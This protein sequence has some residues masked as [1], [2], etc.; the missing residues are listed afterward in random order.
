M[1][2]DLKKTQHK[3]IFNKLKGD[4]FAETTFSN[5]DDSDTF[6]MRWT[7]P[8]SL[9]EAMRLYDEKLLPESRERSDGNLIR[10]VVITVDP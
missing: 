7:L 3:E 4:H 2:S 5:E 10:N 1:R 9:D 8:S 6:N